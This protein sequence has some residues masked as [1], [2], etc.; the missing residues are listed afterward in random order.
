MCALW[1]SFVSYD[2]SGYVEQYSNRY[3]QLSSK[4]WELFFAMSKG[5]NQI[6]YIDLQFRMLHYKVFVYEEATF[7]NIKLVCF[8]T[9][10]CLKQNAKDVVS[11]WQTKMTDWYTLP[12][13]CLES[14][15]CSKCCVSHL[16]RP[17]LAVCCRCMQYN[18]S[19]ERANHA[20]KYLSCNYEIIVRCSRR[21]LSQREMSRI[22]G[23]SQGAIL[24]D[25]RLVRLAGGYVGIDWSRSHPR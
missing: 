11:K 3:V 20:N 18:I 19:N 16:W 14:P 24:K 12:D 5:G 6:Q 8:R 9:C 1:V 2:P 25:L 21:G 22:T 13:N 23:V 10:S 15:N 7:C 17:C 4:K